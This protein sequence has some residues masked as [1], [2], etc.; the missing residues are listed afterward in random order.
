MVATPYTRFSV[1][2]PVVNLPVPADPFS[3]KAVLPVT[4]MVHTPFAAALPVTPSISTRSPVAKF[5]GWRVGVVTTIG[6]A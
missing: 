5:S 2:V 6:V 3:E 4:V 1:C